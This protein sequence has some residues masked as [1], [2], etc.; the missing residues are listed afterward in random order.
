MVSLGRPEHAE[1]P[2][3]SSRLYY[4]RHDRPRI[5]HI[6]LPRPGCPELQQFLQQLR[7]LMEPDVPDHA[8]RSDVTDDGGTER[9]VSG[10]RAGPERSHRQISGHAMP[11]VAIGRGTA[12]DSADAVTPRTRSLLDRIPRRFGNNRVQAEISAPPDGLRSTSTPDLVRG[13]RIA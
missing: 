10:R 6:Q 13:D 7:W 11:A 12:G 8:G 5:K 2:T 9:Q 4:A 1:H 3:P